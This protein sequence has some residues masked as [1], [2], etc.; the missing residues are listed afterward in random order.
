MDDAHTVP[1]MLTVQRVMGTLVTD[2]EINQLQSYPMI[3]TSVG[4]GHC[5]HTQGEASSQGP[6]VGR[7]GRVL[8][9]VAQAQ[10]MRAAGEERGQQLSLIHISEPTRHS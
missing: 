6:Q 9:M 2:V 4:R 10:R 1:H 7:A 3:S 5:G 8:V